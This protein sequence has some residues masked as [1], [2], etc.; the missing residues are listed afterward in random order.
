M[1]SF[2]TRKGNVERAFGRAVAYAAEASGAF[3]GGDPCLLFNLQH[4][5]TVPCAL[6]A[7]RTGFF[8]PRD[9]QGTAK[10]CYPE[11]GAVWAEISAPE[12]LVNE[13]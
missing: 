8:V 2:F 3:R 1:Y 12:I 9:L 10:T 4:T 6:F 7:M 5:G 13:R 11:Q